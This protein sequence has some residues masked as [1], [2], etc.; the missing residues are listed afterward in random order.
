[1]AA[2]NDLLVRN[3]WTGVEFDDLIRAQLWHLK[4]FIGERITLDGPSLRI[5]AE[6]AQT[7]GMAVHEL[8]TNS[9]KHGALAAETG[10]VSLNWQTKPSS[11]PQSLIISWVESGITGIRPPSRKGFGHTVI[12]D[13]VAA[14]LNADVE[15]KFDPDGFKWLVETRANAHPTGLGQWQR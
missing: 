8:S 2:N 13:M 10:R 12:I 7:L 3:E 6:A 11:S 4:D 14:A 15:M 9:L 1:M 5:S